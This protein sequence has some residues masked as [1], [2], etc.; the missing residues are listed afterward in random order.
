MH[1]QVAVVPE[2][3]ADSYRSRL[4]CRDFPVNQYTL[5][6]VWDG[7]KN[8]V[9]YAAKQ[10]EVED[11]NRTHAWL[12]RGVAMTPTR[13]PRSPLIACALYTTTARFMLSVAL[14]VNRLSV[15]LSVRLSMHSCVVA[16]CV[17]CAITRT[18]DGQ[19]AERDLK[20]PRMPTHNGIIVCSTG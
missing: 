9:G 13:Y 15:H 1:V 16:P 2:N 20:G 3:L 10:R 18:A 11:F 17:A 6:Q 4:G 12:K 7:V 19:Q 8:Q 5:P 14:S